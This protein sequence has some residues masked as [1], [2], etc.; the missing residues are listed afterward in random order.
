MYWLALAAANEWNELALSATA[1]FDAQMLATL[2]P[3][4]PPSA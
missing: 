3:K 4:W 1:V 2:K